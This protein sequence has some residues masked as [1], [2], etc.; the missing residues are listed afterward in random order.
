MQ[1]GVNG[2]RV[3]LYLVRT[4]TPLFC[5][6]KFLLAFSFAR[7]RAPFICRHQTLAIRGMEEA[8]L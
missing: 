1:H 8:L 2:T 6:E 4:D 3:A 7:V 5:A